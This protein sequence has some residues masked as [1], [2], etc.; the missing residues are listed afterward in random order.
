VF[1]LDS[2]A[3]ELLNHRRGRSPEEKTGRKPVDITKLYSEKL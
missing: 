1:G 3:S 2:T